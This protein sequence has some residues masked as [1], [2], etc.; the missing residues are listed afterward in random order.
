MQKQRLQKSGRVDISS[1]SKCYRHDVE[2]ET[3]F[4]EMGER[5]RNLK[6]RKAN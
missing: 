2:Q 4:E 3:R 5:V 1:L 6:Q